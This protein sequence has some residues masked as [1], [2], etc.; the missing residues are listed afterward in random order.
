MVRGRENRA[1]GITSMKCRVVRRPHGASVP[2]G[3]GFV[4]TN[5]RSGSALVYMDLEN[6][7]NRASRRECRGFRLWQ[8]RLALFRTRARRWRGGRAKSARARVAR[9]A[10]VDKTRYD[11]AACARRTFLSGLGGA[12]QVEVV[13]L[14]SYLL[15]S[16]ENRC[17]VGPASQV[18]LGD[19]KDG[20]S[21][22][23]MTAFLS[24]THDGQHYGAVL[25]VFC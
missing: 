3:C 13:G 12:L 19:V 5:P 9:A 18:G 25:F 8:R 21:T 22:F 16:A 24:A 14:S 10:F 6:G 23:R 11:V 20:G 7:V 2:H 15:C 4:M 17:R 1:H